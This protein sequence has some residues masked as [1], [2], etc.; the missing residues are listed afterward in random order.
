M[1]PNLSLHHSTLS[2][3]L[4]FPVVR[5]FFS[6]VYP[7]PEYVARARIRRAPSPVIAIPRRQD[8]RLIYTVRKRYCTRPTRH[9]DQGHTE[10][11]ISPVFRHPPE[12]RR[13][14]FHTVRFIP[15]TPWRGATSVHPRQRNNAGRPQNRGSA[16][17]A[18]PGGASHTRDFRD[19]TG[20]LTVPDMH[21][22]LPHPSGPTPHGASTTDQPP[23]IVFRRRHR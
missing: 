18:R 14:P 19:S 17:V 20:L 2:C 5:K 22:S 1:L 12:S 21:S 16:G 11:L 3:P 10:S 15:R 13:Y 9:D 6:H 8:V 7:R 23:R 4:L